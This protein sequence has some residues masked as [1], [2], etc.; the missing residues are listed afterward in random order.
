[1][2]QLL[3]PQ[4]LN[5]SLVAYSSSRDAKIGLN[6]LDQDLDQNKHRIR[7]FLMA[8]FFSVFFVLS[9]ENRYIGH[10][11]NS[12]VLTAQYFFLFYFLPSPHLVR[13]SYYSLAPSCILF[14]TI[15]DHHHVPSPPTRSTWWQP[16]INYLIST[17]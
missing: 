8:L 2:Y 6:G 17:T 9:L 15:Y 12:S 16:I 4:R 7:P 11:C 13:N 1:M 10:L 3:H 5:V 14:T